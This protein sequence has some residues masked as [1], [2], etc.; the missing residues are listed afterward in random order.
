MS[1]SLSPNLINWSSSL[2]RLP[3]A[4]TA[5]PAGVAH[6]ADVRQRLYEALKDIDRVAIDMVVFL[7]QWGC[8]LIFSNQLYIPGLS[9]LQFSAQGFIRQCD[10]PST[11]QCEGGFSVNLFTRSLALSAY[12]PIDSGTSRTLL[13]SL[14]TCYTRHSAGISVCCRSRNRETMEEIDGA[15]Y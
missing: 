7:A 8:V 13:H 10:M 6:Q 15:D 3:V 4:R 1:W 5:Q 9:M 2:S 12:K 14:P 11:E